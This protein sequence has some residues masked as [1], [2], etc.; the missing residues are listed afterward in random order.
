MR[1]SLVVGL[2][3]V[4]LAGVFAGFMMLMASP[5]LEPAP[6]EE[7]DPR[8]FQPEGYE[9]GLW[10]FINA[11]PAFE[12]ASS[13]NVIVRG[14][15]SDIVRALTERGEW[16]QTMEE[17]ADADRETFSAREVN[18]TGTRISWGEAAGAAR[19][20]Y[21]HDGETGE[22]VREADQLHLGTYFGNRLHLRMYESP[23]PEE[24]WV[25]MQVHSEHFDWFTLRHAVDGIEEAQLTLE[26]DFRGQPWVENLYRAWLDN[27]GPAD[28]DGWATVIELA[29]VLPLLST[30]SP[31]VERIWKRLTPVDRR[32]LRAVWRRITPRKLA[33][34]A[35][36]AGLYF[37]VRLAGITLEH[38]TPA[39]AKA[40]AGGLYPVIAFGIPLATYGIAHGITERIDAGAVAA[41]A[42]AAAVLVDYAVLGVDVLPVGLLVQRFGVVVSLGLIGAGAAQRAT[43]ERHLNDLV[44]VGAILWVG[45]LS[46]TLAGWI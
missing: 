1:R 7:E 10:P 31:V 46:A 42:L 27:E 14:N 25:A 35:T 39:P 5:S 15:T 2:A 13:V 4:A 40:I 43:R 26:E 9:S 3:L 34:A 12:P 17:E 21:V 45:L 32:R 36:V 20:A 30:S 41:L 33:L 29:L 28:A 23:H 24:P 6:S 11:R 8:I 44:V 18:V 19:Y 37:A 22:W 16:N 38:T